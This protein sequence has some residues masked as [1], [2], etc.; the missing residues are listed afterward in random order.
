MEKYIIKMKNRVKKIIKWHYAIIVLISLN[1]SCT[2]KGNKNSKTDEGKYSDMSI[3]IDK[4]IAV[5]QNHLTYN[6]GAFCLKDLS[7]HINNNIIFPE[8][9]NSSSTRFFVPLLYRI[10]EDSTIYDIAV[11]EN[12]V[13]D[14]F[15]SSYQLATSPEFEL[16][17]IRLLSL[18]GKWSPFANN[19]TYVNREG[20]VIIPFEYHADYFDNLKNDFV[21]NPDIKPKFNGDQKLYEEFINPKNGADGEVTFLAIVEKMEVFQ[22]NCASKVPVKPIVK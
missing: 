19:G 7:G 6:Q 9:K 15:Y 18:S 17:A 4:R 8:I 1:T 14:N 11:E 16:E 2:I 22:M 5:Q 12:Y 3:Q 20:K 21:L 10:K 13:K